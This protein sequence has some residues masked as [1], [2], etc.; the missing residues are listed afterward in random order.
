MEIYANKS[1]GIRITSMLLIPMH[2]ILNNS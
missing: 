2:G 1:L